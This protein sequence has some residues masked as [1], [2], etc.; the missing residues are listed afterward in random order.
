MR[1][2][3]G[4]VG[5][6]KPINSMTHLILTNSMTT[7]TAFSR[8]GFHNTSLCISKHH[9]QCSLA[10]NSGQRTVYLRRQLEH[11][12]SRHLQPFPSPIRVLTNMFSFPPLHLFLFLRYGYVALDQQFPL[13]LIL[14]AS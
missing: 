6:E 2:V 14:M 11:S 5:M 10:L 1:E 9:F 7:S 12:G 3:G 8:A 4:S 13:P